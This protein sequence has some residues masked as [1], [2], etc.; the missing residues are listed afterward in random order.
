[1][2]QFRFRV[3]DKEGKVRTGRLTAA[4]KSDAHSRIEQAGM[5]VLELGEIFD[6]APVSEVK[7]QTPHSKKNQ[8]RAPRADPYE[9]GDDLLEKISSKVPEQVRAKF[10][11]TIFFCV[12]AA[13]GL[14]WAIGRATWKEKPKRVVV[15]TTK[16]P[17]NVT[18]TGNVSMPGIQDFGDVQVALDFPEVPYQISKKWEDLEHP[19]QG[20][21]KWQ[22]NFAA[23]ISP[24]TCIVRV[25]KPR[26]DDAASA[27]LNLKT[28]KPSYEVNIELKPASPKARA[29]AT[30][31]KR[32]PPAVTP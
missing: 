3:E 27:P 28:E 5:K 23:R 30:H 25:M 1:M 20:R 19:S 32:P 24:R 4:S 22:A 11:P 2:P 14:L 16:I 10:N 18:I 12:L 13:L 9:L 31:F 15:A 6:S 29:T 26:C 7:V 8:W 17:V 21:F